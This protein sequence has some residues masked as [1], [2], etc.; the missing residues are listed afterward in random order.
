MEERIFFA[1]CYTRTQINSG[2]TQTLLRGGGK[3]LNSTFFRSNL[4]ESLDGDCRLRTSSPNEYSLL[5]IWRTNVATTT[6]TN[7]L[8]RASELS[9]SWEATCTSSH[10]SAAAFVVVVLQVGIFTP[11]PSSQRRR[12]RLP[13]TASMRR[14]LGQGARRT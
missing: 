4:S 1:K 3:K 10:S 6:A 5:A 9:G 14:D 2:L 11:P 13:C 7:V 12:A 8:S